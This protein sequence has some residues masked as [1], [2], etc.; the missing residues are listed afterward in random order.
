M[1]FSNGADSMALKHGTPLLP[2]VSTPMLEAILDDCLKC[3]EGTVTI[4]DIMMML[5]YGFLNNIVLHMPENQHHMILLR[6]PVLINTLSLNGYKS[7]LFSLQ[8][9][10]L[11]YIRSYID[12]IH[13]EFKTT[14]CTR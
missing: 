14:S 10:F 9:Y 1:L 2:S 8:L 7:K 13:S 5:R 12:L 3:N 4:A 6:H 11:C